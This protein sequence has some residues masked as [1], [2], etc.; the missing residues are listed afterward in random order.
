LSTKTCDYKELEKH[1]SSGRWDSKKAL[2]DHYGVSTTAL[3]KKAKNE[4]LGDFVKAVKKPG[5]GSVH[6]ETKPH[7]MILGKIA[8]R[9]IEELKKELG[10]HYSQLD[11]PLIVAFAKS[12]ERYIDLEIRMAHEDEILESPK[13]GSRYLNPLFNAIQMVQ[14]NIMTLAGQ[15]G[16]SIASRKRMG[17]V[18][19][20]KDGERTGN[21][22]S[23]SEK[24]NEY[25]GLDLG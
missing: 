17:I 7:A 22:F 6:N 25:G 24:I 1:W 20:K 14:K 18:F 10:D 21:V 2:A 16:L 5:S 13:T 3:N 9:K 12:Y 8:L 4:G 19:D 23:I 15:L 11:E